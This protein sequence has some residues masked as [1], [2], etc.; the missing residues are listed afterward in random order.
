MWPQERALLPVDPDEALLATF[1]RVRERAGFEPA[2]SAS[3]E[4]APRGPPMP[5]AP[6]PTPNA[7]EVVMLL[8]PDEELECLRSRLAEAERTLRALTSGQDAAVEHQSANASRPL[9][10]AQHHPCLHEQLFRT[11]FGGSL[12]ALL[13]ADGDGVYLDANP[14]ACELFGL[15]REQLVGS[16]LSQFTLPGYD[17]QSAWRD[18]LEVGRL[19]GRLALRRPDGSVRQLDYSATAHIL[20]GLHL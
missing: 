4:D 19:R 15:T 7:G 18:F 11:V 9:H 2:Q 13:L 1:A 17:H 14:A 16:R 12:D 10:T 5:P 6:I 8:S 20:P 3:A